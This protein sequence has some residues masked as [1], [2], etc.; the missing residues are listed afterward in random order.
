MSVVFIDEL[1]GRPARHSP[2]ERPSPNFLQESAK[3]LSRF[4]LHF[5]GTPI[6]RLPDHATTQSQVFPL[7]A[8]TTAP[9]PECIAGLFV[10]AARI[11]TC[12][13]PYP[14][15]PN[16]IPR[17]TTSKPSPNWNRMRSNAAPWPNA[18]ARPSPNSLRSEEH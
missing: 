12:Q 18:S 16:E 9:M 14:I 17:S 15:T 1:L 2:L 4:Q 5:L 3:G 13:T 7:I 10:G 8:A 6:F 11:S